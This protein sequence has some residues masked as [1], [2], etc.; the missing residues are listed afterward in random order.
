MRGRFVSV[1]LLRIPCL[2]D[3]LRSHEVK[4]SAAWFSRASTRRTAFTTP[5]LGPGDSV[6]RVRA[7]E[8]AP[9]GDAPREKVGKVR[10]V[11]AKAVAKRAVSD[12]RR[13]ILAMIA[14][15]VAVLYAVIRLLP[16]WYVARSTN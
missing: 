10:V 8:Y 11:L 7:I 5:T 12:A 2:R 9:P 4:F 6:V 14:A 1:T 16:E 15:V 3:L 13:A